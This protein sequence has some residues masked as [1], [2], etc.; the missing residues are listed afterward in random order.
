M[1]QFI[2]SLLDISIALAIPTTIMILATAKV[3]SRRCYLRSE[4]LVGDGQEIQTSVTEH[5]NKEVHTQIQETLIDKIS[6]QMTTVFTKHGIT[7]AHNAPFSRVIE[8]YIGNSTGVDK[9][10][11]L[12]ELFITCSQPYDVFVTN[13]VF[14]T[15]LE[16]YLHTLSP[17]I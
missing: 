8:N 13:P 4:N 3:I 7:P 11:K 14:D 15:F 1:D 2:Q 16:A 17:L 5:I 9:T 6:E 10:A 12:N